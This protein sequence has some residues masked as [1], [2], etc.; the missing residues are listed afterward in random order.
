MTCR[1]VRESW[2]DAIQSVIDSG[3]KPYAIPAGASV[4]KFGGL[5]YVEFAQEVKKQ[6]AEMGLKFEFTDYI[7]LCSGDGLD[8]IPGA[9]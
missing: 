1:Y 4:H 7:V 9:R 3:G 5:G 2:E 6:E 8:A